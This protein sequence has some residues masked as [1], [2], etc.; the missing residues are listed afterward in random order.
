MQSKGNQ[1]NAAQKRWR[2]AVRGIGSILTARP[3]VIHHPAGATAKMH[4]VHIG[5]HWIIPLTDE[6][7][8]LLHRDRKAFE[9]LAL[10]Y[11]PED[12]WE[13]E[14]TLFLR[15]L[16]LV[17]ATIEPEVHDAILAFRR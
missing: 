3:A 8:K 15:V 4:K 6:E 16:E 2:K 13:C 17:G 14:K 7:H 12:R 1:P 5:H 11:Q 9:L 10:G